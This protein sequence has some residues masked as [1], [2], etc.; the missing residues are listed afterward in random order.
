MKTL[1]VR[2]AT[3]ASQI[4]INSIL[5]ESGILTKAMEM[6]YTASNIA[7]AK[8]A[9]ATQGLLFSQAETQLKQQDELDLLYENAKTRVNINSL[10][11]GESEILRAVKDDYA[12]IIDSEAERVALQRQALKLAEEYNNRM[13]EQK[14]NPLGDFSKVDFEVFG[15][16]GNPFKE[17]LDGLNAYISGTATLDKKIATIRESMRQYQAESEL[18]SLSGQTEKS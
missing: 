9:G 6:G 16:F 14:A 8:L 10:L 1:R 4:K 11:S 17:A 7:V 12:T 13:E 3:E 15:S 18:A 2:K 5:R